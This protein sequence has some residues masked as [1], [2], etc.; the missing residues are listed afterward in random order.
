MPTVTTNPLTDALVPYRWHGVDFSWQ[1]GTRNA[2]GDCPLCG[3]SGK[4]FANPADGAWDCKVC[5]AAGNLYTFLRLLHEEG[6]RVTPGTAL[7]T[8]ARNRKLLDGTALVA[9][10]V[11][12]SPL[13]D[14][15]LLPGYNVE[16]KLTQLYAYRKKSDRLTWLPTPTLPHA[17][18]YSANYNTSKP[19]VMVCYSDD[20]EVLTG[21][22]WKTFQNL[23]ELDKVAAYSLVDGSVAFE[24][25]HARQKFEHNGEMVYF[26]SRW[27]DLLV[28]PDHRM[29]CKYLKNGNYQVRPAGELGVNVIL[30]TAGTLQSGSGMSPLHARLLVAFVADGCVRRGFQL[31]FNFYKDRKKS[32]LKGLLDEA[33]I[34]YRVVTTPSSLKNGSES[35]LVDRR[36]TELFLEHCPEKTWTGREVLWSIEARRAMLD[37]L[38]YWDGDCGKNNIRYFTSKHQQADIVSRVAAISGY[39]CQVRVVK[40]TRPEWSDEIIVSLLDK[41]QRCFALRPSRVPYSGNVYCASVSTGALVVRRNG[42]TVV[43]GNCEGPWDGMALWEMLGKVK[44]G[45]GY[46][47]HPTACEATSLAA[48]VNVVAVPGCGSI[49]D[50][51]R[52]WL[53]LFNGKRVTL[54]FDSDHPKEHNGAQ[55]PPAGYSACQRAVGL[56]TECVPP[57]TEVRYLAWGDQG[58]DPSRKSG[59][60]L[61]DL[62][63]EVKK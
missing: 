42:K 39:S 34:P 13:T 32:R 9:W 36:T 23:G 7:A 49:G 59:Y 55:V 41:Q 53:P 27:S 29:I 20:T 56:L 12:Q 15:W 24:I 57:P 2:E 45:E 28:T 54:C 62:L 48:T 25:P 46:K 44:A 3:K 5:G 16:G 40:S 21:E 58:Y 51:F 37:E 26:K 31:E 43:S 63:T 30:P 6:E 22:G 10:G 50:P 18:H 11:A 47:L 8:L 19:E 38:Q 14:D 61:R 17:L 4:W 52:R 33:G 60:D 1:G 35:I